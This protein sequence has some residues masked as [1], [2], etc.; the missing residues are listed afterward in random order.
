MPGAGMA[1][2]WAST[3]RHGDQAI[4]ARLERTA[5]NG[6]ADNGAAMNGV[7]G[8]PHHGGNNVTGAPEQF[9]QPAAP[10]AGSADAG[11]DSGSNLLQ[12][13]S[14]DGVAGSAPVTAMEA[15]ADAA[16][17]G[18]PGGAMVL[19]APE[20]L[21]PELNGMDKDMQG[22]LRCRPVHSAHER[23][24]CLDVCWRRSTFHFGDSLA[25]RCQMHTEQHHGE[26][27]VSIG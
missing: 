19:P 3:H 11:T 15:A 18:L 2:M 20:C 21:R 25:P 26:A 1:C 27:P 4:Q 13:S 5:A 17:A 12:P 16:V 6:S 8:G 14:N 9:S 22:T 10:A 23:M 7:S 24:C